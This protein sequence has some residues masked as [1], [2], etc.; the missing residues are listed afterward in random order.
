MTN[1]ETP[2]N[3][4][5]VEEKLKDLISLQ[6]IYSKIDHIQNVRGELPE[7][8]KDLSDEIAGLETRL[9]NL[10]ADGKK[11]TQ[12]VSFEKN[13]IQTA[14]ELID[15]YQ[16]QIKDVKNNREY[17]NLSKEIEFQGLEIELSEK[18]IREAKD[19]ILARQDVMHQIKEAIEDTR[20]RHKAKEEELE[21]ITGETK[22]EEEQLRE[23]AYKLEGE[24]DE[25]LLK[26]F[27]RI[28][29]AARNGLGVVAIDRDACGGCFN[30]IPPQKQLDIK[31]H[32]KVIVCEYCGR[33]IVD[34][35]LVEAVEQNS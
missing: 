2:E 6:L 7:E 21:R 5:S 14:K 10:E 35:E 27:K 17:D 1:K 11:Q 26:A 16:S 15:K 28:R 19:Q 4:K 33:I 30:K 24:I 22:Q 8:V 31:L 32:K 3:N 20:L 18:K 29:S 25:R 34:P 23:R 12:A 13:K 9:E